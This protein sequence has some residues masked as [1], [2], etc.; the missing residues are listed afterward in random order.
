MVVLRLTPAHLLMSAFV[1]A[2]HAQTEA[3]IIRYE[4][5]DAL[6]FLHNDTVKEVRANVFSE[7][8]KGRHEK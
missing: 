8:F 3:T 5:H 7:F 6:D 4:L 1:E 2:R